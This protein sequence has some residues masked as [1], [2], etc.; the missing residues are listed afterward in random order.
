MCSI[1]S[2]QNEN[3]RTGRNWIRKMATKQQSDYQHFYKM[4]DIYVKLALI[5]VSIC[6]LINI[7]NCEYENTWNFYYE[8]PCCGNV[9]GHHIRHHRGNYY[10]LKLK[11][12]KIHLLQWQIYFHKFTQ[13]ILIERPFAVASPFLRCAEFSV[14]IQKQSS[15]YVIFA[16]R[17]I[18]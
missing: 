6:M 15:P 4:F 8:Q 18:A 17:T 3:N 7:A 16:R 5:I 11:Q 2:K 10:H 14:F 13:L 12:L 1:F 9:N